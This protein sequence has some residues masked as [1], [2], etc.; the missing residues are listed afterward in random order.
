MPL[1]LC[2]APHNRNY[3]ETARVKLD[4]SSVGIWTTNAPWCFAAVR[5]QVHDP[6]VEPGHTRLTVSG[7]EASARRFRQWLQNASISINEIDDGGVRR[8][9]RQQCHCPG[10]RRAARLSTKYVNRALRFM[11]LHGEPDCRLGPSQLICV[12]NAR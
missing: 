10:V 4:G 3:V 2:G 1:R 7:Y 9:A 12:G 6:L 8:F 5:G 11:L